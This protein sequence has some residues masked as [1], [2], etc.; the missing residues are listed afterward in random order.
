[1]SQELRGKQRDEFMRKYDVTNDDRLLLKVD[2]SI[3]VI[4]PGDFVNY[5]HGYVEYIGKVNSIDE[6][7]SDISSIYRIGS[8]VFYR[9]YVAKT[10]DLCA[11]IT[12]PDD[13][14]PDTSRLIDCSIKPDDNELAVMIKGVMKGIT[15]DQLS[16]MFQK[17]GIGKMYNNIRREIETGGAMSW[18]RFRLLTELLNLRYDLKMYV[19]DDK[20]KDK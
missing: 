11:D 14:K 20:K 17:Y 2:D 19:K 5:D 3:I 13:V 16:D 18:S 15:V 9:K 8:H 7:S 10:Q 1:M 6:V 12:P 4:D